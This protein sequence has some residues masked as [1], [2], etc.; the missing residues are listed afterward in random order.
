MTDSDTLLMHHEAAAFLGTTRQS[1]ANW[2]SEGGGPQFTRIGER[3][4]YPL[5]DL[6]TFKAAQE[7]K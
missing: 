4:F 7:P 5:A 3:I 1:L 2:R 6:N